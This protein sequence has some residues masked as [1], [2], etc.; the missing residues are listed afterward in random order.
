MTRTKAHLDRIA[1]AAIREQLALR[2]YHARL[3]LLAHVDADEI[4]FWWRFHSMFLAEV[5]MQAILT[6]PPTY[7]DVE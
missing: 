5:V 1:R 7:R 4:S 3:G 6:A 2:E